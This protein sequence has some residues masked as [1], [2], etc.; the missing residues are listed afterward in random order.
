MS[1]ELFIYYVGYRQASKNL[2][3]SLITTFDSLPA[4]M[5]LIVIVSVVLAVIAI[6]LQL[7]V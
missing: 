1:I 4:G 5:S 6:L 7:L 2:R 3:S